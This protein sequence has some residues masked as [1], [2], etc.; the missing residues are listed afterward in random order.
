MAGDTQEMDDM[1]HEGLQNGHHTPRSSQATQQVSV[2]TREFDQSVSPLS[3]WDT[4][5]PV[6]QLQPGEVVI[7]S[8]RPQNGLR[9]TKARSCSST[10]YDWLACQSRA[11]GG[12][13]EQIFNWLW[14]VVKYPVLVTI[15]FLILSQIL[16]LGY[17]FLSRAYLNSFCTK[18][19]SYVR[20][21]MC[22]EWDQMQNKQMHDVNHPFTE[23]VVLMH[24]TNIP[25]ELPLYMTMWEISFRDIRVNLEGAE[26]QES[27]KAF[28]REK[29][30]AY[31]ELSDHTIEEVQ[32]MFNHISNTA[33]RTVDNIESMLQNLE[34]FIP[35]QSLLSGPPGPSDDLLT[36]GMGWLA[37]HSFIYLPVGVEPFRELSVYNSQLHAIWLMEK[38]TSY[39]HQRLLEELMMLETVTDLMVELADIA[40]TS[41]EILVQRHMEEKRAN[42]ARGGQFWQWA[43]A[44]IWGTSM[45]WYIGNQRISFFESMGPV[46]RNVSDYLVTKSKDMLDIR[47]AY[48]IV[49]ERLRQDKSDLV[50]GNGASLW[51]AQRFCVLKEEKEI[52]ER[53]LEV[54]SLEKTRVQ[55]RFH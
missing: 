3:T 31:L 36:I 27:D 32:V 25:W 18:N 48:H 34:G 9:D 41:R 29:I 8:S 24:G 23:P 14:W 22:S 16:A 35:D 21:W 13:I 4:Y 52:L 17:T 15:A 49:Q 51:L 26:L 19:L 5:E 50:R 46:C 10:L 54:W 20:D 33:K 53:E 12:L 2:G 1:P 45:D 30:D 38:Y 7:D 44:K 43:V 37:E 6:Q 42:V 55:R 28:F 40:D 47:N 11:L 39:I